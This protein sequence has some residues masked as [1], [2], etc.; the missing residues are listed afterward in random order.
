MCHK[1]LAQKLPGK[2]K[3]PRN[4]QQVD[5][6]NMES[7]YLNLDKNRII[8]EQAKFTQT[9]ISSHANFNIPSNKFNKVPNHKKY[10]PKPSGKISN[11]RHSNNSSHRENIK[12]QRLQEIST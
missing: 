4:K 10:A 6:T 8:A 12:A 2:A 1:K 3:N 11:P 9:K 7:A 5:L